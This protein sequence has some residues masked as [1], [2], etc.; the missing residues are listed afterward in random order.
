MKQ[1][2]SCRDPKQRGNKDRGEHAGTSQCSLLAVSGVLTC[3]LRDKMDVQ[4]VLFRE[5]TTRRVPPRAPHEPHE[6]KSGR[7]PVHWW[8]VGVLWIV[9]VGVRAINPGAPGPPPEKMVGVGFGGLT[10]EPEEMVGALGL[11]RIPVRCFQR[12]NP[13]LPTAEV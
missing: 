7:R 10:T 9:Q 8:V 13:T 11:R 12:E 2:P 5:L 3:F 4:L 6:P 1:R